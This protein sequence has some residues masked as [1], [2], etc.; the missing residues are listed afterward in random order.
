M[1]KHAYL[2]ASNNNFSVLEA[3]I[4]LVDDERNDLYLL[5]DQ[6]S[7]VS[8]AYKDS[9]K[10]RA[11]HSNVTILN[12]TVINW[13]G[14]RRL[15]QRCGSLKPP[16]IPVKYIPTFISYKVRTCQ[17]KRKMKYTHS[18][19]TIRRKTTC[20]LKDNEVVWRRINAGIDICSA[21]TDFFGG[22]EL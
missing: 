6:K 2:I 14:G 11:K 8:V 4:D 1:G 18:L 7:N 17:L 12:D 9:F 20:L 22:T 5:F 15:R 10:R 19:K 13:G 16:I 3:C 21:I